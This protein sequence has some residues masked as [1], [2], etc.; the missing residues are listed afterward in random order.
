MKN[1]GKR[2]FFCVLSLIVFIVVP[3]TGVILPD[4]NATIPGISDFSIS[5]DGSRVI[6]GTN[7]GLA[8]VYDRNG[9]VLWGTKTRG[10]VLAGC[11]GDGTAFLV[12]SREGR[13]QNKGELRLFSGDG[14]QEWFY[15]P[16]WVT[17]MGLSGNSIVIGDRQGNVIVLDRN[18]EEIALF[19]D[20]PKMNVVS[21]LS[22]SSDGGYVIYSNDE[23]NPRLKYVTI[24][25]SAKRVFS[26]SYT[27]T[28]LYADNE[29]IRRIEISGDG[30]YVATAGGEGNHGLL[31]FYAKNGTRMWSK[32]LSRIGDL[33]IDGDGSSVYAG[34]VDGDI[35]GYSR[36]GDLEWVFS[37]GAGIGSL[38][39]SQDG[40]LAAGTSNGD[41]YVFNQTGDLLWKNRVECFPAGD[42][43][44]V[45][46]SRDGTALAASSNGRSFWYYPVVMEPGIVLP[47]VN[48]T[49]VSSVP[50]SVSGLPGTEKN[51]TPP[52]NQNGSPPFYEENLTI[53]GVKDFSRPISEGVLNN[54]RE[55][56]PGMS[57]P[58][59]NPDI[60]QEQGA[61]L[62]LPDTWNISRL[63]DTFRH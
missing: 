60:S 52:G 10:S 2:L 45:E 1:W 31:V 17:A 58:W 12:A 22:L 55:H 23:R 44:R 56:G 50:V 15:N 19:N 47:D 14:S 32:D 35:R 13:E 27:Y 6:I 11:I 3:G 63:F 7:T 29:P 28:T 37:T 25:T 18:G 57:F 30:A 43:S 51:L 5:D 34:T 21:D 53:P 48:E 59:E 9:T 42:I 20:Y 26:S 54:S 61:G 49:P 38:S 41:L 39:L 33:E 36:S 62:W 40:M 16:G 4:W 46:I 8:R 24:S